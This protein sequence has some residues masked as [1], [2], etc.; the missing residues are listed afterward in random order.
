M[1]KGGIDND[2]V[3]EVVRLLSENE[4]YTSNGH[5]APSYTERLIQ[6]SVTSERCAA[7]LYASSDT[8]HPQA[9]QDLQ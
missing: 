9:P 2:R 4:R 7:A 6:V 5:I 8:L 3:S 1:L